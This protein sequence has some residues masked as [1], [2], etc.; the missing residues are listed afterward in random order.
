MTEV[1]LVVQS[2]LVLAQ[3]SS[4]SLRLESTPSLDLEGEEPV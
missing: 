1:C 2:N 3:P 4:I